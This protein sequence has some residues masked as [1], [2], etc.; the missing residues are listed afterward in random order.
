LPKIAKEL[1]LRM[2]EIGIDLPSSIPM[3]DFRTFHILGEEEAGALDPSLL[4]DVLADLQQPAPILSWY[5]EVAFDYLWLIYTSSL[6][7]Q[8]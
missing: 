1:Q 2:D 3:E 6:L 4:I 7:V 5:W 8:A